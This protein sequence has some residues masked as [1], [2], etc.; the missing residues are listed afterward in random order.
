[1]CKEGTPAKMSPDNDF[2]SRV[3][4]GL[5]PTFGERTEWIPA[6]LQ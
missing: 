6:R 2:Y 4:D 5:F 1:M 3:A